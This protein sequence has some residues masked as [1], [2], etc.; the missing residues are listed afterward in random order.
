MLASASGQDCPMRENGCGPA[1]SQEVLHKVTAWRDAAWGSMTQ[2]FG[3][4][5][6]GALRGDAK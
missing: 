5:V 6:K 3:G 4:T 1:M 2:G